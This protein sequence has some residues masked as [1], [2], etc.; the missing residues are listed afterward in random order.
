[1]NGGRSGILFD[2]LLACLLAVSH[3][4]Q[5]PAI[6]ELSSISGEATA[7]QRVTTHLCPS[8]KGFGDVPRG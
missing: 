8:P 4:M 5:C 2:S 1:M 7:Q 6:L 3:A